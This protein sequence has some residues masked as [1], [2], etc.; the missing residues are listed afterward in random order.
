M[1]QNSNANFVSEFLPLVWGTATVQ[2]AARSQEE[3]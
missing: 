2:S 3:Q 1:N